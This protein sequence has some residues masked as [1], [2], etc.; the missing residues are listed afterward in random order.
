MQRSQRRAHSEQPRLLFVD[1]KQTELWSGLSP[2]HQQLCRDLLSQ[3]LRHLV[4]QPNNVNKPDAR[5]SHE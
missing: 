3:L 4:V 2:A 1:Q 5:S